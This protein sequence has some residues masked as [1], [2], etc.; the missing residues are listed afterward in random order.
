MGCTAQNVQNASVTPEEQKGTL[1]EGERCPRA[2]RASFES[3]W[4]CPGLRRAEGTSC[5]A[6]HRGGPA[7]EIQDSLQ[8]HS[9]PREGPDGARC[10]G[11]AP[12]PSPPC[13]R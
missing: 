5:A 11:V 4:W 3:A 13:G 1:A 8:A 12:V 9:P 2:A 10:S 6:V 7:G